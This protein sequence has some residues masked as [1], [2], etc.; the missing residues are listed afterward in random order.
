MFDVYAHIL[1][2]A[3]TAKQHYIRN[4]KFWKVL[5][6]KLDLTKLQSSVSKSLKNQRFI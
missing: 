1:S 5:E 4:N 2:V 3:V 6:R